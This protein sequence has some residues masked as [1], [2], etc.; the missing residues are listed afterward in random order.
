M[1]FMKCNSACFFY[2]YRDLGDFMGRAKEQRWLRFSKRW[3]K[4]PRCLRWSL[5][6]VDVVPSRS[7]GL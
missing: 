5:L 1:T 3:W 4:E 7:S 2:G 6:S